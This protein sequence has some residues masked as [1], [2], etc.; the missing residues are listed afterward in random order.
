MKWKLI[1]ALAGL[2]ALGAGAAFLLSGPGRTR[3][4]VVLIVIDSLRPDHLG[5]YGYHRDTS[6]G[7]DR[8]AA[9]GTRFETVTSSTSWTLPAHAALFTSLPDS[10]HG[11]RDTV[12]WLDKSRQTLAESFRDAG[13]ETVGFFAGPYLHPFF[14]LSQGFETYHDCTS[15]SDQ[16]IGLLKGELEANLTDLS[17]RD[18]TGPTTVREVEKWLKAHPRGPRLVFLHLWDVHFDYIPPPPY[19]RLYDSAY[20]GPVNGKG[21]ARRM[22][23]RPA[24]WTARDIE[25]LEAL[26]DGEI[27]WT[28][29]N[30]EKILAHLAAHGMG[31]DNTI[32][33]LTADH[34]EAFY[35]HGLFG[36][37]Q[38]LHEEEI[39]IP[40]IF[41]WPGKIAAGRVVSPPARIIDIAPTLL[42]LAGLP[43]MPQAVGRSLAPLL[44]G[45][46]DIAWQ[47]EPALAELVELF[48]G[49]PG[50]HYLAVRTRRWKEITDYPNNRK[51]VY[52]MVRD[53]G[54]Q[55]PLEPADYPVP[56]AEIQDAYRAAVHALQEW[57][58]AL[59]PLLKRDTP[60]ITKMSLEMLKSLGYLK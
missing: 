44:H 60:E 21:M 51:L 10:V 7:I 3:P 16:A 22:K 20:E 38:T 28:D 12:F 55:I 30:L 25:H 36:H 52:D 40:L 26:Y 29:A 35:E 34:G 11:C 6:P 39:R 5:C 17:I 8:L 31:P 59:S 50:L 47:E 37:M 58:R 23:Q 53:P 54:E 4:S 19:D 32:Y 42:D 1:G 48:K 24:D 27:R 18:V 33:C 45:D 9:E 13:Y 57:R 14:G 43:P 15:Y 41:H 56:P 46:P 49:E 2:L